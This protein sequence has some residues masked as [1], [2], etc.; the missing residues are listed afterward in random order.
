M[1][2]LAKIAAVSGFAI[3][4]SAT[5]AQA[6]VITIGDNDGYGAGIIDNGA[7]GA[8]AVVPTDFRSGAEAA[9]SDGSQFT[10]V[11]SALFP[12]SGP[13]GSASG[14]FIFSLPGA[15][16]S[17]TLTIDMA[18]FQSTE[19]GA[20][21]ADINGVPFSLFF[22]DGFQNSVV[23]PFALSVAQILAINLAGFLSL[24]IDHTGSGDYIAFDYLSLDATVPIPAALPLLAAGLG[25]MGLMG[26]RRRQKAIPAA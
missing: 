4:M 21:A 8:F 20:V 9:A 22:D 11:Y 2:M 10:D 23:R 7:T 17:G 19:F 15:I 1:R 18:D 5:S 16:T 12:G 26:R 3:A 14:S 25:A 6:I 13:N 24:N